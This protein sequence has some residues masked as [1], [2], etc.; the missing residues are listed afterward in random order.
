MC[1]DSFGWGRMAKKARYSEIQKTAQ[2]IE[3]LL[4][5]YESSKD[6]LFIAQDY[7]NG[8]YRM[9]KDAMAAFKSAEDS[10]SMTWNTL[11][12]ECSRL[13]A[14]LPDQNGPHA[15]TVGNLKK[16]KLVPLDANLIDRIK[17]LPHAGRMHVQPKDISQIKDAVLSGLSEIKQACLINLRSVRPLGGTAAEIAKHIMENPGKAGKHIAQKCAITQDNFR[18]IFSRKLKPRGFY[19]RGGEGYFAPKNSV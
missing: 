3:E 7:M 1:G 13:V 4:G 16:L 19:N 15:S 11:Y 10:H 6:A 8:I 14:L 17:N 18:R 12:E 5:Q 9:L 2:H